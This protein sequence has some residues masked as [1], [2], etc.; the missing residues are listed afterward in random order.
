[1]LFFNSPVL[2]R[3]Y[4]RYCHLDYSRPDPWTHEACGDVNGERVSEC[5]SREQG[6]HRQSRGNFPSVYIHAST[7]RL[8]TTDG[9][10]VT[11]KDRDGIGK[12]VQCM[13]NRSIRRSSYGPSTEVSAAESDNAS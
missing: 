5:H 2:H 4:C 10:E 12:C 1:M 11:V 13:V 6:R 8:R 7:V 9:Q 3:D